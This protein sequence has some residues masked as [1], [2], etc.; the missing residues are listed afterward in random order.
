[1]LIL[2]L[3]IH[4]LWVRVLTKFQEARVIVYTDDGYIKTKLSI[5]LQ[6]LSEL[7][8]VFKVDAV[9]ELN[10]SKTSILPAKG[11]TRQVVFDVPQGIITASP[12][13]THL[14]DD[15]AMKVSLALV[16]LLVRTSLYRVLCL[17]NVGIS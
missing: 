8:A 13:L 14:S 16:F 11:V 12:D 10:V 15:L 17:K 5:D 9:L 4:H 2:N 1:M 3:T 7:K 6:V